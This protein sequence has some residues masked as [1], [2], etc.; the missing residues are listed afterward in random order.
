M[1]ENKTKETI[2]AAALKMIEKIRLKME[3]IDFTDLEET[4]FLF[5]VQG[6]E[7]IGNSEKHEI[8]KSFNRELSKMNFKAETLGK[9]M[10]LFT[11]YDFQF[12]PHKFSD[13]DLEA[14]VRGRGM[15]MIVNYYKPFT[16]DT[17]LNDAQ[18]DQVIA[19][20]ESYENIA[21]EHIRELRMQKKNLERHRRMIQR[22][23]QAIPLYRIGDKN[24][25]GKIVLLPLQA[26]V[27]HPAPEKK[28][29]G[30][31]CSV[32]HKPVWIAPVNADLIGKGAIGMCPPCGYYKAALK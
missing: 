23:A 30:G 6:M 16:I 14:L 15:T 4:F 5:K 2:D 8:M 1:S 20:W 12:E 10:I 29:K 7:S 17:K 18:I 25:C 31:E 11:P 3:R 21:H 22:K 13:A 9:A 27:A 26:M 19:E 24:P 28:W 32:C